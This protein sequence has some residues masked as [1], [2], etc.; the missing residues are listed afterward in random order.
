[1]IVLYFIRPMENAE[2][3]TQLH[4]S[5]MDNNTQKY[6]FSTEPIKTNNTFDLIKDLEKP[7][8]STITENS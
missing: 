1:M 5:T 8:N 4:S 6:V 3:H 7:N 2:N